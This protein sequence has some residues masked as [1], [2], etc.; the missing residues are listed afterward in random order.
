LDLIVP[1]TPS[2][3]YC[4]KKALFLIHAINLRFGATSPKP[5]PIP[6]TSQLPI[7]ADN[8]IPSLLVHLGVVDISSSSPLL[9]LLLPWVP[10]D[11]TLTPLLAAAPG[12]DS[13]NESPKKEGP[14]LTS[15]QAYILRAAAIDACELIVRSARSLDVPTS[16]EGE[17]LQ[18]INEITLPGLDMWLWA[19]A[20]DRHDY[21]M[22]ERFVQKDTVFF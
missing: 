20:K 16:P 13:L 1:L 3:I 19:V 10:T 4:F 6:S 5:F 8:V 9:P 7:F 2:A 21:R 18:W 14:I 15:D 11:E 17:S 22:L 12:G